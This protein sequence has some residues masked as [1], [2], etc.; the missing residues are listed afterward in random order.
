MEITTRS[1]VTWQAGKAIKEA[2]FR[3][4]NTMLK[5]HNFRIGKGLCT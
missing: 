1:G 3:R 2:L 5:Y 4:I